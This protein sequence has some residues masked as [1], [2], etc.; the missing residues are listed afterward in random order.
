[1][2]QQ[3]K[4]YV[5]LQ[6]LWEN[7]HGVISRARFSFMDCFGAVFPSVHNQP[8]TL[9]PGPAPEGI[10]NKIFDISK[11][12]QEYHI[13]PELKVDLSKI[14]KQTFEVDTFKPFTG[15]VAWGADSWSHVNKDWI[16]I[17]AMRISLPCKH[18]AFLL[19]LNM[20]PSSGLINNVCNPSE[21]PFVYWLIIVLS[22]VFLSVEIVDSVEAYAEMLRGIFD[23]AALKELLSGPG[24]INV[25]LDAMH[26]GR[27]PPHSE[28][29]SGQNWLHREMVLE[30]KF[31][32]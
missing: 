15:K 9:S 1:M 12:L 23:F 31:R 6:A 14:G 21:T 10:T 22:C 25:R 32:S 2:S 3:T 7:A 17:P 19:L 29:S 28:F 20:I 4:C 8:F 26:G 18:A 5:R 11:S 16:L 13:C 30:L 27:K 24:H